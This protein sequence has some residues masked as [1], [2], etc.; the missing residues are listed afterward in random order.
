ML[1]V[2]NSAYTSVK[3]FAALVVSVLVQTVMAAAN[4]VVVIAS[5]DIFLIVEAAAEV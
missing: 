5:K 4:A 3:I 1:L 2:F